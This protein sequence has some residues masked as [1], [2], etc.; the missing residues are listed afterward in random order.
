MYQES[1]IRKHPERFV[2]TD[3]INIMDLK[4]YIHDHKVRYKLPI[5]YINL[6]SLV[7]RDYLENNIYSDAGHTDQGRAVLVSS[8]SS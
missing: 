2:D 1:F 5:Q 8:S 3:W 6:F 7:H 4:Q